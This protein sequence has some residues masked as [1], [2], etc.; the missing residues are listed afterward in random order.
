MTAVILKLVIDEGVFAAVSDSLLVF[1]T[2]PI[3]FNTLS[4]RS[5]SNEHQLEGI[6]EQVAGY[7]GKV[8]IEIRTTQEAYKD[9]LNFLKVNHPK[10][11]SDYW[12][13]PVLDSGRLS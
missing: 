4:I 10:L 7:L 2:T 1:E 3:E 12:V 13:V 6:K 11:E 9:I 8:Q 5:Y